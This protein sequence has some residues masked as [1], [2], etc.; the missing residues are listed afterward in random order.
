[1]LPRSH[2]DPNYSGGFTNY[3]LFPDESGCFFTQFY[4]NTCVPPGFD[5]PITASDY[6]IPVI[7]AGV[8]DNPP[9]PPRIDFPTSLDELIDSAPLIV[10]AEVGQPLEYH[11]FTFHDTDETTGEETGESHML[12]LPPG[13][14]TDF[15]LSVEQVIRSDGSISNGDLI[16]IRAHGH[17]V[18]EESHQTFLDSDFASIYS[19]ARGLFLL[20]RFA[21]GVAY[22]PVTNLYHH[23]Q[24]EGDDLHLADG[25][26]LQFDGDAASVT[27]RRFIEMAQR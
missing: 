2:P 15:V 11:D 22:G 3:C 25:Q 18:S 4:D 5:R 14:A 12:P 19:G 16:V 7:P 27:L 24:I 26:P 10:I 1:M 23:L 9:T 20:K 17:V 21:D 13:A 8:F 6:S